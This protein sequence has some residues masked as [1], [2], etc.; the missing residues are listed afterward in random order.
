MMMMIKKTTD[1]DDLPAELDVARL[2]V[3]RKVCNVK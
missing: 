2:R 3:E 1:D